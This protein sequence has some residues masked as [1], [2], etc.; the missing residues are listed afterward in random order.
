MRGKA[1]LKG[2]D[3]SKG[4]KEK[5]NAPNSSFTGSFLTIELDSDRSSNLAQAYSS[6]YSS[7]STSYQIR[8]K[9]NDP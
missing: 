1:N 3:Q 2:K 7:V 6:S 5:I 9:T 4:Y 8:G